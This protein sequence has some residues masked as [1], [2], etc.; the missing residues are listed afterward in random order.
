M[1]QVLRA[2]DPTRD[3]IVW[4]EELEGGDREDSES[5]WVQRYGVRLES[6]L[7]Y[8]L[9][10]LFAA[11]VRGRHVHDLSAVT[12]HHAAARPLLGGHLRVWCHACHCGT[13]EGYQQKQKCSE[14]A[15][16]LHSI[17]HT[18]GWRAATTGM[19]SQRENLRMQRVAVEQAELLGSQNPFGNRR[20]TA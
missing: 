17:K 18:P 2:W 1:R 6:S 4:N 20:N 14:L 16:R 8:R 7:A 12:F 10:K 3:G 19:S 11:V 13:H 5:H 15:N 9:R